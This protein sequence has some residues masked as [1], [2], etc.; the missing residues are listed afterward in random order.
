MGKYV[1]FSHYLKLSL[2]V[3]YGTDVAESISILSTTSVKMFFY[4]ITEIASPYDLLW[5]GLALI[6]A[7]KIPRGLGI[8]LHP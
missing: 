3:E 6:T 2:I 1:A 8:N 7:W 5:V 4:S